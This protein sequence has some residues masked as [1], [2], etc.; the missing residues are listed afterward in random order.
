MKKKEPNHKAT[1]KEVWAW[2]SAD[3]QKKRRRGVRVEERGMQTDANRIKEAEDEA[4]RK[5]EGNECEVERVTSGRHREPGSCVMRLKRV[6]GVRSIADD[7]GRDRRQSLPALQAAALATRA[8]LP[9]RMKADWGKTNS[10][11]SWSPF[12]ENSALPTT[13]S[14]AINS[15]TCWWLLLR[16]HFQWPPC[17]SCTA[18]SEPTVFMRQTSRSAQIVTIN[19]FSTLSRSVQHQILTSCLLE[20]K[21]VKGFSSTY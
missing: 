19:W 1:M 20:R 12:T 14:G 13:F 2:C 4:R 11:L 10:S 5:R 16:G 9:W 8:S 18:E 6:C 17:F 3:E 15:S 21:F 7:P